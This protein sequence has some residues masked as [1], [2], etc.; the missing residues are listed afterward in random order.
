MCV[1]MC[2]QLAA[3]TTQ[4]NSPKTFHSSIALR[5]L[6]ICFQ[7]SGGNEIMRRISEK[8]GIE[9]MMNLSLQLEVEEKIHEKIS[10]S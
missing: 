10:A 5:N 7:N 1:Y 6:S 8:W 9:A 4:Y 3:L 2:V